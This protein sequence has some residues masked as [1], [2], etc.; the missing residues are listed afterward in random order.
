MSFTIARRW[1]ANLWPYRITV[2]SFKQCNGLFSQIFPIC[3][4]TTKCRP[5]GTKKISKVLV[6]LEAW[7]DTITSISVALKIC[8]KILM[9]VAVISVN[10]FSSRYIHWKIVFSP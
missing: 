9:T 6:D 2:D 8:K 7:F 3:K 4:V 1:T 5:V 10:Y